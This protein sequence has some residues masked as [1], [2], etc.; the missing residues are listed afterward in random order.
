MIRHRVL[1]LTMVVLILTSLACNAF[2]GNRRPAIGP[3]PTPIVGATG[4]A[5]SEMVATATLAGIEQGSPAKVKILV[6]LNVRSGPGV[7]YDR[8]G[9]LLED[10]EAAVIGMHQ[11]SGWWLIECPDNVADGQCWISGGEQYTKI[12]GAQFVAA[13]EAPPTPTPIPPDI[14]DDTGIVAYANDGFL[15]AQLLDLTQTPPVSVKGPLLLADATAIQS[16][17]I[18]PDGRRVAYIAGSPEANALYVV[19]VDGQDQ[20]RLIASDELPLDLEQ[21]SADFAVILDQIA[22]LDDSQTILFNTAVNNLVGMG[23]GSQEDLWSVNLDGQLQ[24]LLPA[25]DGGGFFAVALNGQILLSRAGN[26]SRVNADGSGNEIILDFEP[27]NTASETIY[28]PLPQVRGSSANVAVPAA[29]PFVPDARTTLWQIPSL[30]PAVQLG[31]VDGATL[32][33]PI[34]WSADGSRLAYVRKDLEIDAPQ[35]AQLLIADSKGI[36]PDIYAA[37]DLLIFHGWSP[38]SNNFIYSG[39]GFYTVGKKGAPPAQTLLTPGYLV[40]DAQWINDSAFVTAVGNPEGRSWELRSA[41]LTGSSA[42][43]TEIGGLSALFDVW[44]AG[45]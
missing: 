28:Y 29:Q 19:N 25:G 2:A 4:A 27:I 7:Q 32:F 42:A 45:R 34:Y 37:G 38:D 14:E 41:D 21:N 35:P 39:N 20:R 13:V 17:S 5:T 11:E 9:F 24:E 15:Y 12:E 40:S 6:D 3:A 16:L 33:D 18:S 36:N 31:T 26:I 44:Q 43:L 22:W 8:V 1:W 30:G 10:D 23:G